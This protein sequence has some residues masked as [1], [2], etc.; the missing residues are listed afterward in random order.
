VHQ[1][2]DPDHLALVLDGHHQGRLHARRPFVRELAHVTF[3]VDVVVD[4]GRILDLFG[5]VVLEQ[6]L[7]G[8]DHAAL[9]PALTVE[10]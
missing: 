9:H 3:A 8:H 6:R 4:A 10:R 7:A 5:H 2:H 1:L